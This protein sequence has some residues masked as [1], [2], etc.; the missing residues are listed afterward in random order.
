[1]DT[2]EGFEDALS[3]ASDGYDAGTFLTL[4]VDPKRFEGHTDAV[5]ALYDG[6][7]RLMSWLSTESRLGYTPVNLTVLEFMGNGL[8]HLHVC[9]FG[10]TS[11]ELPSHGELTAYWDE[12][13]D[14]GEQVHV[15]DIRRRERSDAWLLRSVLEGDD[16]DISLADYLTDAMHDLVTVANTDAD[17]LAD[18]AD[19]GDVSLWKQALYWYTERRY[20]SGS[21]ALTHGEDADDGEDAL[22][23]VSRWEYVGTFHA[24]DIPARVLRDLISGSTSPDDGEEDAP[25]PD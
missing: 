13:R 6:K 3:R 15:G 9:M 5:E 20:W 2:L 12:R 19:A 8:P 24:D 14:V 23:Y 10:V 4:T 18:R 25:P 11:S 7:S 1:V 17:D 22:P 21:D 16:A